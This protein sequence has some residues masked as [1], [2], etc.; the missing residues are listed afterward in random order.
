MKILVL[1]ST[2]YIGLHLAKALRQTSWAQV[3]GASRKKSNN[4]SDEVG[5]IPLDTLD[6][7]ALT[8]CLKG[9][10]AVVNC[11]AGNRKS[12][13][14]GSGDLANAAT[15]AGCRRIIHLSTMSVYGA[16]E[17]LVT[18]SL[19]LD[20]PAG[21]Y[22]EAKRQAEKH[23]RGFAGKGGEVVILRPGCV[24]GPG[25]ELWVG[26]TGRWL[27]SRR[28]GDLGIAGDGWSNLVHVDNVCDAIISAL[29][30]E[31]REGTV[32]VFNLSAPDSPR[33]NEYFVD[34]ALA[35][36]AVPV[37]RIG[38]LQLR[39]DSRVAGPPL[40]AAELLLKYCGR[41]SRGMPEAIPSGLMA[42]WSQQ[43]QLDAKNASQKLGVVWTPYADALKCSATWFCESERPDR[44]PAGK[45]Y[46][47]IK[48]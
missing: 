34:L 37:R 5:W 40:K 2:G 4:D 33:W 28:L 27:R 36:G 21:W 47:S 39:A 30:M 13:A 8:S 23:V 10:D 43:I 1:G 16:A 31:I 17:G 42:L 46:A 44:Q 25:S 38:S 24:F 45:P 9:F 6:P 14:Q 48:S 22:G 35:I 29:Q 7:T 19:P 26:R 41:S 15:L 3:T 20:R 32:P 18:E 12:I 11:V